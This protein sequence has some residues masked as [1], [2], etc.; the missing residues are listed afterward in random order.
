M[1]ISRPNSRATTS[2]RDGST[3]ELMVIVGGAPWS[4]SLNSNSTERLPSTSERERTVIGNCSSKLLSA[5]SGCRPVLGFPQL[6]AGRGSIVVKDFELAARGHDDFFFVTL[7]F[8]GALVASDL[9]FVAA[10]D[11]GRLLTAALA[12][13]FLLDEGDVAGSRRRAHDVLRANGLGADELVLRQPADG[14]LHGLDLFG[15]RLEGR[16]VGGGTAWEPKARCM[17]GFFGAGRK[18]PGPPGAQVRRRLGRRRS[19]RHWRFGWPGERR[20]RFTGLER[21]CRF[22]WHSSGRWRAGSLVAAAMSRRLGVFLG[23]QP[24]GGSF[25]W[26]L[27]NVCR[28][29]RQFRQERRMVAHL[30]RPGAGGSP[31]SALPYQLPAAGR[32]RRLDGGAAGR[33][34]FR[35]AVDLAPSGRPLAPIPGC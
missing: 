5:R 2:A 3:I 13:V 35:A 26:L 31:G 33:G 15:R 24:G 16:S 4:R 17:S 20:L 10:D 6:M 29:E 34:R 8:L 9:A 30:Q 21:S 1:S 11:A 27:S 7:A 14:L 25:A 12:V 32:R 28:L 19:V 22:G 23:M 18:P